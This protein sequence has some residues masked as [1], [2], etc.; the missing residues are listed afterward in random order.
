MSLHRPSGLKKLI[1][2]CRTN[3][4][5]SDKHSSAEGG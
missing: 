2:Q 1:S 5:K 4:A 3:L